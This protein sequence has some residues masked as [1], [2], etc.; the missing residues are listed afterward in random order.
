MLTIPHEALCYI[1]AKARE[2]A[3][4]APGECE[5]LGSNTADDDERA[6]LL[7][8]PQDPT[9]LELREAIDG[10]NVDE[11]EELLALIWVGRGD[12]GATEWMQAI[13]QARNIR[14]KSAADYLVGTPLLADY[15]EGGLSAIGESLE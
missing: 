13:R 3:A 8:T 4:V 12:F 2:F 11:R 10:L 1:I 5:D 9:A 14:N 7:D 6:I 15:L